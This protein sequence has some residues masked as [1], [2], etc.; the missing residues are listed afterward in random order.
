[1]IRLRRSDE[2]WLWTLNSFPT[3]LLPLQQRTSGSAIEQKKSSITWHYRNADPDYGSFQAKECQAHMENLTTQ[4]KLAVEVLVGK[5]NL[6]VRPLAVN[7]GEIVKR[8]LYSN[9]DADFVFCAG[10]DKTDED[11]FRA[12]ASLSTANEGALFNAAASNDV[13]PSS[14]FLKVPTSSST[15]KRESNQEDNSSVKKIKGACTNK[16]ECTTSLIMSAPAPLSAATPLGSPRTLAL[17]REGIFTTTIGEYPEALAFSW[18][19]I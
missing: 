13:S 6:E 14:S 4:N 17:T 5:K 12:L 7:K 2:I 16:E 19:E 15:N 9:A 10:D 1:V 3:P 11:M 8:I 18:F